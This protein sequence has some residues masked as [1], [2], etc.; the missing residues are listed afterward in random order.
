MKKGNRGGDEG[1]GAM[2]LGIVVERI[3]MQGPQAEA[4][5]QQADG[6]GQQ[7]GRHQARQPDPD[8]AGQG[9]VEEGGDKDAGNDG[10]G[11]AQARGQD[12]GEQ[13]RLVADLRQR[14]EDGRRQE[15]F[16]GSGAQRAGFLLGQSG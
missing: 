12:E 9:M 6:P 5:E 16:H 1:A 13:L 3:R 4:D 10:A 2:Q 8:R 14:D 11:F 7:P 15:G